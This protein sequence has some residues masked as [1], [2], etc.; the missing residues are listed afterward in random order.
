MTKKENNM[1]SE[2]VTPKKSSK[3]IKERMDSLAKKWWT[4]PAA[5][6][7]SQEKSL[8]PAAD[9]KAQTAGQLKVENMQS[10]DLAGNKSVVPN[11]L[12]Q[13]RFFTPAQHGRRAF[14]NKWRRVP[15]WG[16][17]DIEAAIKI[18]H[19]NQWDFTVY[20]GLCHF[21]QGRKDMIATFS[22]H[23]FL[24][25]IKRPTDGR[26]HRILAE[27]IQRLMEAQLSVHV[28]GE[29]VKGEYAANKKKHYRLSG[30]LVS[31]SLE[32][33]QE[34]Q[35]AVKLS[36]PF[37]KLLGVADWSFI[38]MEERAALGKK[39]MALEW[40]A[41]LSCHKG[42]FWVKKDDLFV[43]WGENYQDQQNF[44]KLFKKRALAPLKEVGFIK[45]VE[46]KKSAI[47]IYF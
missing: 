45:R 39:E 6:Q 24:K 28:K 9:K 43:G 37:V 14:F 7:P 11:L 46:D 33:I 35:Y 31:S 10:V 26:Y 12:T 32:D 30:P 4:D 23:E 40:H 19:L 44:L 21:A 3:Q 41:F 20:L 47:G 2:K 8:F 18:H 42:P 16:L 36:E 15:V 13:A 29:Y 34:K 1:D 5:V 38:N 17:K 27:T 25:Y 22:A